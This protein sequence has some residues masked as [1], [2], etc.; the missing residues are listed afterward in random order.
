MKMINKNPYEEWIVFI[1]Y[2]CLTFVFMQS[3]IKWANIS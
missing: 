3:V 2:D 1:F